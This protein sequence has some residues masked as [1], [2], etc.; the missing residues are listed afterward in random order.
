[1]HRCYHSYGRIWQCQ[2]VGHREA[3]RRP[4]TSAARKVPQTMTGGGDAKDFLH[5]RVSAPPLSCCQPLES[6]LGIGPA[7]CK[8]AQHTCKQA[9][10][11]LEGADSGF[12]SSSSKTIVEDHRIIQM[13]MI[14]INQQHYLYSTTR[15]YEPQLVDDCL[16]VA[17]LR[18]TLNQIMV[19]LSRT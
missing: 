9:A 19:S 11:K 5:R 3:S 14:A 16:L 2:H 1:M 15:T 6:K 8:H 18:D 17:V 4:T 13:W 12:S 7:A 10:V